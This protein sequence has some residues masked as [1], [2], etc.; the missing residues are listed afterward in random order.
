M[1]QWDRSLFYHQISN[2]I[3]RIHIICVEWIQKTWKMRRVNAPKKQTI[4][5]LSSQ[6]LQEAMERLTP[7]V[8]LANMLEI[9]WTK[10]TQT[11]SQNSL[12]LNDA[13]SAVLSSN[14]YWKVPF[15][16]N[17]LSIIFLVRYLYWPIEKEFGHFSQVN[18]LNT[19]TSHQKS[20]HLNVDMTNY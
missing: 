6:D 16:G 2:S 11:E 17:L 14:F 1:A 15:V 18:H 13:V 20:A 3:K 12:C 19:L 8:K 10:F 5:S 9:W 4:K 7:F